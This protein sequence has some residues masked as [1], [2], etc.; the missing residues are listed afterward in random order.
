M[1]RADVWVT[2]APMSHLPWDSSATTSITFRRSSWVKLQNSPIP[3][4]HPAPRV[5]N[6]WIWRMLW[7]I[8]VSSNSSSGVK[9]VI[10]VVHWPFKASLAHS[11]ASSL[12]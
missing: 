5:P 10:K 7:R 3:Q 1:A 6:F 9:G 11:C 8:P 2:W 12:V 4:V